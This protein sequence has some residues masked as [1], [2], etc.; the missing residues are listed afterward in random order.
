MSLWGLSWFFRGEEQLV[1]EIHPLLDLGDLRM[2]GR[3]LMILPVLE[4]IDL[5]KGLFRLG[6]LRADEM[7]DIDHVL[8]LIDLDKHRRCIHGSYLSNNALSTYISFRWTSSM[9]LSVRSKSLSWSFFRLFRR[10]RACSDSRIRLLMISMFSVI[11]R[12][13]SPLIY[14]LRMVRCCS[15]IWGIS[16]DISR[17]L[18]SWWAGIGLGGICCRWE[19]GGTC[20]G[21]GM[22]ESGGRI[23][24][25]GLGTSIRGAMG[26]CSLLWS[27][28]GR[29]TGI[30]RG[31]IPGII[32]GD[33][34][35]LG[36]ARNGLSN[37]GSGGGT[38]ISSPLCPSFFLNKS[39]TPIPVS[40]AH[41]PIKIFWSIGEG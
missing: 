24:G 5:R 26:A 15:G 36:S 41:T 30:G 27:A 4:L 13:S 38:G 40:D 39:H 22:G 28:I 32:F 20:M 25:R 33:S 12:K 8:V 34:C 31:G 23:R 29:G 3:D 2:P 17:G 14:M 35:S 11:S 16:R 21:T 18:W 19:G 9:A 7:E 1:H 6:D 10:I 37:G